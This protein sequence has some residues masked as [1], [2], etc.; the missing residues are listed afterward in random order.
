MKRFTWLVVLLSIV[1]IFFFC[2]APSN[3]YENT[4][5]AS[6]EILLKGNNG[7]FTTGALVNGVVG[8]FDKNRGFFILRQSV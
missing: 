2:M 1:T 7:Q 3:P 8:R 5:N 6:L 4:N